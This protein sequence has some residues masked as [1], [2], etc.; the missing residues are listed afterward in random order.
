M[1]GYRAGSRVAKEISAR[2]VQTK[3]QSQ[4]M[5]PLERPKMKFLGLSDLDT[6]PQLKKIPAEDRRVM[7]LIGQV[8][9]FRVNNYVVEQLIDWDNIPNDPIY[10][11]TFLQP[12]MLEPE[13]LQVLEQAEPNSTEMEEAI[14]KIRL[15][16][17]PHPAEQMTQNVPQLNGKPVSGIQH[18]YSE[19]CLVFPSAGQTCFAY[20]TFCFRWPQFVGDKDLKF[21]TDREASFYDYIRE[22]KEITDVLV[23]GGDPMIMKGK[24]LADLIEPFLLPEFDHIQTIRIGTKVLSYWPNRFTTDKDADQIL[25]VFKKVVD[26]G[27]CLAFMAHFSHYREL[28]TEELK[29]AVQKIRQ[30]GAVIRTQSPVLKHINDDPQI[31]QKMWNKQVELGMV[32]YYF[33]VERDTGPKA[34]F[35]IPLARAFEIY[36]TAMQGVS[37]LART[38]RGPSMSAT[39]GKIVVDGIN[40]IRGEKVFA[41]RFLQARDASNCFQPFYAQFD[42]EATWI[43][44][45]RP[46]FG[47]RQFFFE[48][49][50]LAPSTLVPGLSH[51][52]GPKL[53]LIPRNV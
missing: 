32:P 41:L 37:G 4:T 33:F 50:E 43:D 5:P 1:N 27:K 46:A 24:K 19:T 17:N 38:A 30:T 2:E 20:C 16:L 3:A 48:Q 31:W 6:H 15:D 47:E 36:R 29:N 45:L 13:Q 12:G 25:K 14:K 21:A 35:E 28:E 34:Y 52:A 49:H 53:Q 22:H 51:H 7:K 8:L 9:A 26:S 44:D 42:S 11:L 39:L 10:Q 18:K 40:F 23:T